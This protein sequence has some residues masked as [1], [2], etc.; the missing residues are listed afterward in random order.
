MKEIIS[1]LRRL[2]IYV[3]KEIP[4]VLLVEVWAIARALTIIIMVLYIIMVSFYKN[5]IDVNIL[6]FFKIGSL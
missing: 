3:F 2:L 5:N 4:V 1:R 6:N